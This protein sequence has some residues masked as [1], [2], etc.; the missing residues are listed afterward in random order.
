MSE[1]NRGCDP[2][3]D[4]RWRL[5]HK[6]SG[7]AAL[8]AAVLFRR[9][10][11]EEFLLLRLLGIIRSGPRAFPGNAAD[12]F[13]SRMTLVGTEPC[14]Q[15]SGQLIEKLSQFGRRFKLW[16]GIELLERA[17]KRIR[18][19]PHRAGRELRILRLEVQAMHFG[20]K[21]ARR[22]QLAIDT[23]LIQN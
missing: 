20:Q 11:A 7:W 1:L 12:W 21:A 2:Q 3:V 18:Q 5:L 19:A 4:V 6:L 10:L 8:V 23:S 16:N 22:L 15:S 9:N 17:G 14:S 13:R